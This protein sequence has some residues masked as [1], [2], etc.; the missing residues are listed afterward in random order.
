[1]N[2]LPSMIS[3]K[4][5]S[6]IAYCVPPPPA[7]WYF[8]SQ[9]PGQPVWLSDHQPWKSGTNYTNTD[10][11]CCIAKFIQPSFYHRIAAA[12]LPGASEFFRVTT[13]PANTG[14]AYNICLYNFNIDI[15]RMYTVKCTYAR[16]QL[17]VAW[18]L[19]AKTQTVNF[20]ACSIR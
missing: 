7:R 11:I 12:L 18:R 16:H 1:M 9:G 14:V 3:F 2:L 13:P 15:D 5:T 19:V 8:R 10:E 6:K 17:P 4:S 20:R